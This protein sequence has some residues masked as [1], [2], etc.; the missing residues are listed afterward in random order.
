MPLKQTYCTTD[1][2]HTTMLSSS[3]FLLRELE[4]NSIPPA[5]RSMSLEPN[6]WLMARLL[7]ARAL[8]EVSPKFLS[9]TSAQPR[10]LPSPTCQLKIIPP[11]L[12]NGLVAGFW[13]ARKLISL[14]H[15]A[16]IRSK[17]STDVPIS[18]YD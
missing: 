8:Y 3:T 16:A 13:W 6:E 12:H 11:T 4:K 17:D 7:E 10:R 1:A 5:G 2:L 9:I 14:L 15:G 18:S